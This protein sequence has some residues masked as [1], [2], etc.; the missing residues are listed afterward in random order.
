MPSKEML[1]LG[2]PEI[3]MHNLLDL[4]SKP[5]PENAVHNATE[6][7]V[8]NVPESAVHKVTVLTPSEITLLNTAHNV[9]RGHLGVDQT[10]Q[11]VQKVDSETP[12]TKE[13]VK[14]YVQS[15]TI[16]QKLRVT[17][18]AS[19]GDS[20]HYTMKSQDIFD[21]FLMDHITTLPADDK[22]VNILSVFI[23]GPRYTFLFPTRTVSAE[24]TADNLLKVFAVVSPPRCLRSDQGKAFTSK[25]ILELSKTYGITNT[26]TDE[27]NHQQAGLIER[28]HAEA[29]RHLRALVFAHDAPHRWTQFLP[30]VQQIMNSTVHSD[31]KI[32][33]SDLLFGLAGSNLPPSDPPVSAV[34]YVRGLQAEQIRLWKRHLAYQELTS[35]KAPPPQPFSRGTWVLAKNNEQLMD[36]KLRMPWKGPYRVESYDSITGVYTVHNPTSQR[37]KKDCLKFHVSQLKAYDASRTSNPV[38]VAAKDVDEHVVSHIVS[39]TGSAGKRKT[40]RFSVAFEDGSIQNLPYMDVRHLKAL[41]DYLQKHPDLKCQVDRTYAAEDENLPKVMYFYPEDDVNEYMEGLFTTSLP[42]RPAS[43]TPMTI[44]L[45]TMALPSSPA[46]RRLSPAM[47]DLLRTEVTKL[48]EANII[49]KSHSSFA[50]PTCLVRKPDGSMRFCV[51]YRVINNFMT[52]YAFP[53]PN[54]QTLIART[55]KKRWFS[56]VD[57]KSGFFQLPLDVA[58]RWITAFTTPFGLFQFTRVPMGLKPS[59]QWFQ[60]LVQ[61][62]LQ[63]LVDQGL[64]SVYIDDIIIHADSLE[65][66]RRTTDDIFNR[67]ARHGLQLNADKCELEQRQIKFLGLIVNGEG[68]M[69]DSK[70][71]HALSSIS[72]PNTK[73][74]LRSFLGATNYIRQYIHDYAKVVKPLHDACTADANGRM[75]GRLRWTPEMTT[76]FDTIKS[77]LQSPKTLYHL[78]YDRPI[79]LRTDASVDGIGGFLFQLDDSG[80][81]RPV[82][83]LSKSFNATQ[84]NW[85]TNEQECF[86]MYYCIIQLE[87]LLLGHPFRLQTDHRNLQFIHDASAPKVIRWRC[88]LQE[89][90]FTIEHL[91]GEENIIADLLSRSKWVMSAALPSS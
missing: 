77:K 66:L 70:R 41:T 4:L 43:V 11:R 79:Y 25:V 53:L 59:P 9:V 39:H 1:L 47:E 28:T 65:L 37:S 14:A 52:G 32:S 24:E 10:Y 57:F 34:E 82:W 6:S 88:R 5:Q 42:E 61:E 62:I 67:F 50:S 74:Q 15:C 72:M 7:A 85:S 26:F 80:D 89:Y 90:D 84:R 71:I 58:S 12:I 36:N 91:P 31:I 18:R 27:Y 63:D 83:F 73:K 69:V 2:A 38:A 86:A 51:D 29:L 16:C 55:R 60:H 3:D 64:V 81:V 22:Y 49:E 35:A 87:P 78:D 20:P 21:V 54:T 56:K 44:T 48:L 13:A 23:P 46:P 19:L 68:T 75:Q 40:L 30:V 76:A 33:P 8:H 45:T 17:S